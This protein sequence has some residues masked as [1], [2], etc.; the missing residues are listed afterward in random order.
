MKR[1]IRKLI[2]TVLLMTLILGKVFPIFS[3]VSEAATKRDVVLKVAFYEL[4]GFF[5]YNEEGEEVGYGVDVLN[6]ITQYTGIRFE[7]V[8]SNTWEDTK[9]M[10]IA[11]EADIRMPASKPSSP[12]ET[13]SYTNESIMNSYYAIM[14]KKDREDLYY[15]DNE[16]LSQI[17]IA[18]YSYFFNKPEVEKYL[19]SIGVTMDQI[20]MCSNYEECKALLDENK[21]D[22]VISDVMD[23]SDD[24][25]TIARFNSLSSYISLDINSPYLDAIDEAV[26]QIKL[27]EPMYLNDRYKYYYPERTN[28]P[29]TKNEIEYISNLGKITFVMKDNSGYLSRNENGEFV[30]ICPKISKIICDK[31]NVKYDII[32]KKEYE[33]NKDE[34]KNANIIFATCN[35]DYEWASQ[36]DI[37]ITTPY[38]E[39]NFYLIERKDFANGNDKIAVSKEYLFEKDTIEKTYGKEKIVWY[40][41]YTQ[42]LDAVVNSTVG[43]TIIDSY[44]SEYYLSVYTYSQLS[45]TLLDYTTKYCYGVSGEDNE[46]LVQAISKTINSFTGEYITQMVIEV[47]S[48]KPA[49]N[50]LL[51]LIYKYPERF[52]AIV[53]L[54]TLLVTALIFT[55]IAFLRSRQKNEQLLAATNAK[56]EFMSRMSHDLRTPMYAVLGMTRLAKKEENIPV[57]VMKYLEKIDESGEYLLGLIN[58]VLDMPKI[59]SGKIELH[60]EVVDGVKFL[61]SIKN[62]FVEIAKEKNINLVT[63]F[64]KSQTKW[65]VMDKLRTKQIYSN[66]LNNAIKFSKPGTTITWSIVDTLID[67]NNMHMVCRISDEGCGMSRQFLKKIYIPFEQEYNE[68]IGSEQGNGLGLSIVYNIVK[69]MKGTIEINSELGVGTVVTINLDRKIGKNP[70]YISQAVECDYDSI[71]K[72]KRVLVCE[73]HVLNMEIIKILLLEKEMIVDEAANGKQALMAFESNIDGFYDIILM[74]IRMPIMDGITTTKEIR[75]I[76]SDYA[77]EI[78]IIAV[79]ANAFEQDMLDYKDA[80]MNAHLSKPINPEQL[81]IT[82][83]SLLK[84]M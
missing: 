64:S 59:E 3:E 29:L 5:E 49:Q 42:C 9:K 81:Y 6:K 74:D 37:D 34:Y 63:D 48:V 72:G 73:D 60:E 10:I 7:Y 13:L 44:T 53:V 46:L 35:Y 45:T 32:T 84:E 70:K 77:R 50:N 62:M 61:E 57:P 55:I 51:A 21:V 30:G 76:N 65:V 15:G 47:T 28:M 39:C 18:A 25:K 68:F 79:T 16:K 14:A 78:S 33:S 8:H 83:A 43:G 19:T 23:L 67:D 31:L 27:S 71:L 80:G 58:D 66:I 11:G 82:M 24:L 20:T 17:K 75:K 38:I 36:N 52:F 12:S 26:S 1:K 54:V 4:D 56:T 2:S 41:E 22:A 40:D 69:Q